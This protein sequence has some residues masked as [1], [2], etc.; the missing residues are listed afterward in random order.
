MA[1]GKWVQLWSKH[2]ADDLIKRM[3]L[4]MDKEYIVH[5]LPEAGGPSTHP[6]DF[7]NWENDKLTPVSR[8]KA[9]SFR[10]SAMKSK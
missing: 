9:G 6:V 8:R 1:E 5:T 4:D 10:T 2:G 7:S 3:G